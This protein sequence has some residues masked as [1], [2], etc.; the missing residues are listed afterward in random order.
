MLA[1]CYH[2]RPVATPLKGYT[3]LLQ[4]SPAGILA[5]IG[6]V[7]KE[8]GFVVEEETKDGTALVTSTRF[9]YND[10]G[11]TQPA[12]G[13]NYYYRLKVTLQQRGTL[14]AVTLEPLSLA[15][16]S[17]YVY[18]ADGRAV[19]LSKRYPYEEFPGMFE[20][21]YL[22]QELVRVMTLLQRNTR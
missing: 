17:T 19:N 8:D 7:L 16:S 22:D 21:S 15:I 12:G 13:R 11:V 9:F 20:L 5:T 14:V 1:G 3:F 6:N 18:D 4:G 2:L 10:S